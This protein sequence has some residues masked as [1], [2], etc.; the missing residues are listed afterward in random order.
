MEAAVR[1]FKSIYEIA[2]GT[3][4][5]LA[6]QT[7]NNV[8]AFHYHSTIKQFVEAFRSAV[9]DTDRL[10]EGKAFI[11]YVASAMLLRILDSEIRA[12]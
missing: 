5:K 4:H 1:R 6:Y 8:M 10:T 9:A 3:S 2:V 12:D 7:I 11:R